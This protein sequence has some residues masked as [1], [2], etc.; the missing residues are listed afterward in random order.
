LVWGAWPAEDE[1]LRSLA[2]IGPQLLTY[3]MSFLTL[4]IFWAGQQT[5]LNHMARSDHRPTWIHLVFLLAV[6]LMPFSTEF[7]ATYITYPVAMGIYWINLFMLGLLLF[8]SLAYASRA[9]LW[10][11][12][13]SKDVIAASRRRIIAYQLLYAAAASL[14]LVN[15]YLAIGLLFALQLNSVLVPPI[16]PLNRF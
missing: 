4:R 9:G 5:Q 10:N 16:G 11:P 1:L 2:P 7:L 3:C 8:A 14:C 6:A 13:T 15:T 12:D